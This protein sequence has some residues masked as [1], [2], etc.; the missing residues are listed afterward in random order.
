MSRIGHLIVGYHITASVAIG[1]AFTCATVDWQLPADRDSWFQ[2]YGSTTSP[3][4]AN[5]YG[6]C[7]YRPGNG[8]GG[9]RDMLGR[10]VRVR[11]KPILAAGNPPGG[12]TRN[13][14]RDVHDER[15]RGRV[16]IAPTSV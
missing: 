5:W 6:L 10:T 1:C 3:R 16:D 9:L 13:S 12:V 14:N 11:F 15:S 7:C 4:A 8:P 2:P